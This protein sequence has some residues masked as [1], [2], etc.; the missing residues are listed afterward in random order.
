LQAVGEWG[1]GLPAAKAGRYGIVGFCWG[2][3][4]SFMHA[5]ANQSL[6]AAV[7]YYGTSPGI[8]DLQKIKAPVLGLYG[9]LDAR[10]NMTIDAADST[11]KAGGQTYQWQKY[12]GA[13][14]GF[15]R[16]QDQMNGANL[17]AAKLA[18]PSTI[19]WFRKYI[20]K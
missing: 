6:G 17:A 13:G 12:A 5:V 11:M 7:V 10:V 9:E 8:P 3:S 15:L 18:W 19:G 4:A 16:G 1:M 2:G 14:H 20:G